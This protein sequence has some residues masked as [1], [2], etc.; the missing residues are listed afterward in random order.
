MM[1][2]TRVSLIQ[3]VRDVSNKEAWT[4]FVTIYTPIILGYCHNRGIRAQDAQ[5]V[6]QEV[7]RNLA[8]ALPEFE[9]NYDVGSFRSWLFTIT[10]NKVNTWH[11]KVRKNHELLESDTDEREQAWE[12]SYMSQLFSEACKTVKEDVEPESWD[13]FWAI[14]MDDQPASDL[15]Q[16]EGVS[17][18]VIY[19]RKSRVSKK[20]KE[21]IKMIDD[22]I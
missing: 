13:T 19:K 21:A 22:T 14:V 1:E 11:T 5:D 12:A 7:F 8:K 15:A 6:T 16:K 9:L 3:R 4:Q 20:V 10:R 17:I 2:K 18:D